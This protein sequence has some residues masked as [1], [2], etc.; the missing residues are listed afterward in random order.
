MSITH[1]FLQVFSTDLN[2]SKSNY[3]YKSKQERAGLLQPLSNN[4]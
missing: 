4:W 2:S 3:E 1:I